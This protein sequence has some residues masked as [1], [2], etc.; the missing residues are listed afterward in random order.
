MY[1]KTLK[2]EHGGTTKEVFENIFLKITIIK[3][4]ADAVTGNRFCFGQ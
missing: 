4:K 1:K 3:Y 2:N